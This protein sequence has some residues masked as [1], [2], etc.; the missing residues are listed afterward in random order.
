MTRQPSPESIQK[1][2]SELQKELLDHDYR[3]YVLADPVI[4]DEEYD[5]LM[6]ELIKLEEQYPEYQTPESP[7]QRVGGQP[8]RVFPI[9]T[10]AIPMLSLSNTYNEDELY[11]FD[12]RVRNGVK[13]EDVFYVRN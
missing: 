3:Y 7:T 10:H 2:I 6:D 5:R 9:V 11:D 1:R 13:D 8:T 4:S 12:R